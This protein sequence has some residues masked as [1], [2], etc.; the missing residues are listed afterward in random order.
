[1]V[2]RP[3]QYDGR[4]DIL[5]HAVSIRMNISGAVEFVNATGGI[6]NFVYKHLTWDEFDFSKFKAVFLYT[7]KYGGNKNYDKEKMYF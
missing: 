5:S 3:V 4:K 6:D 7:Y 2:L 1:M